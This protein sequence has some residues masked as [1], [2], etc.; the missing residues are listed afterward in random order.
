[1]KN[2]FFLTSILACFQL[3][4]YSQITLTEANAPKA[5]L[6]FTNRSLDSAWAARLNLGT[7]GTNKTWNFSGAVVAAGQPDFTEEYIAAAGTPYT[8]SFPTANLVLRQGTGEDASYQYFQRSSAQYTLLGSQDAEQKLTFT[9]PIVALKFPATYGYKNI[10]TGKTDIAGSSFTATGTLMDT[11]EIDAWGSITTPR[12]TYQALRL[13]RIQSGVLTVLGIV[14][15]NLRNV[16]YE[17]YAADFASPVFVY[18]TSSINIPLLNQSINDLTAHFLVNVSTVGV[19]DAERWAAKLAF[20][21]NPARQQTTLTVQ[22]DEQTVAELTVFDATGR[23]VCHQRG[24]NLSAGSTTHDVLLPN[25]AAGQ[26][27]AILRSQKGIL[28]IQQLT[29]AQ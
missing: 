27:M 5:G 29:V 24:L 18:A 7:P 22:S 10:S 19:R 28:G 17:W 25:V 2:L 16:S 4:M 23:L 1:M 6:K 15:A 21:P 11:S 20:A 3:P 9:P 14:P 26:Y 8:A 12:G 13:R